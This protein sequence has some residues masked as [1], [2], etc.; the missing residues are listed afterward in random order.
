MR[1]RVQKWGNS[2]ALRIPKPFAEE[3]GMD[4]GTPVDL[5][6]VDGKLVVEPVSDDGPTLAQ[7]LD[8]VT[9]RN[10]HEATDWGDPAGSEAW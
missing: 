3:I 4:Q 9:R 7:L 5:S 6:L 1:V 10:L 8:G 2:L